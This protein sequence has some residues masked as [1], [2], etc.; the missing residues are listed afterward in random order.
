MVSSLY[1]LITSWSFHMPFDSGTHHCPLSFTNIPEAAI[2]SSKVCQEQRPNGSVHISRCW[3]SPLISSIRS[4]SFSCPVSLLW[5]FGL[6][7]GTSESEGEDEGF[8]ED[9]LIQARIVAESCTPVPHRVERGFLYPVGLHS[10]VSSELIPNSYC[11]QPGPK[12]NTN[13]F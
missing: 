7:A 2:L 4:L 8:I 10:A 5:V 3:Q 13:R 11:V 6:Y 9:F 12:W 1:F